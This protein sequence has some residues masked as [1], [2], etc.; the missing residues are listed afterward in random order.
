MRWYMLPAFVVLGAFVAIV[1]VTNVFRPAPAVDRLAGVSVFVKGYAID[2]LPNDK[3]RLR[4]TITLDS[5][6]D[7]D[8]CVAFTLDNPFAGRRLEPLSG[9]CPPPRAGT[10][11]VGLTFE[12]LTEDDIRFPSHTV[13]WGVPGGRCGPILELFGVCVVE[14]AGTAELE[15]PTP[16]G[17][18]TFG[19]IGS[20]GPIGVPL[21]SFAAP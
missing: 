3:H 8:E 14:Q 12:Q 15:L 1:L 6:T 7:I 13:V 5:A 20:F 16:P 2:E 4:L 10:M 18:P 19:P 9:V 11:S 21:Y 17:L